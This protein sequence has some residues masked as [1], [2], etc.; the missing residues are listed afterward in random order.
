MLRYRGGWGVV[1]VGAC[2]EVWVLKWDISHNTSKF[3]KG[4]EGG[5]TF[6]QEVDKAQRHHVGVEFEISIG[7]LLSLFEVNASRGN[8]RQRELEIESDAA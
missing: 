8:N 6:L 2:A 7:Q 3:F 4:R 5:V 1:W